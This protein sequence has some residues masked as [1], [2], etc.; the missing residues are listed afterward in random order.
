MERL[1]TFTA[2]AGVA[3][4]GTVDALA[5]CRDDF[6]NVCVCVCFCVALKSTDTN[7][8]G[9]T[10]THKNYKLQTP[11]H[12]P[13]TR[14][15]PHETQ[16]QNACPLSL[17]VRNA[18]S[19]SSCTGGKPTPDI[20]TSEKRLC[21]SSWLSLSLFLFAARG[22]R[23]AL[24]CSR[25]GGGTSAHHNTTIRSGLSNTVRSGEY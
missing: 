16:R 5:L 14:P 17:T 1:G 23:G 2:Q 13:Q 12:G 6:G 9:T 8:T 7:D 3:P 15:R 4:F 21:S 25:A 20:P 11:D 19:S 18:S 24:A 22:W 10:G